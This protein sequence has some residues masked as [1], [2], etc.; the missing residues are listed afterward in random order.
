VFCRQKHL[1][2][3]PREIAQAANRIPQKIPLFFMK[4]M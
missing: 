2:P 3:L 4:N 1:A